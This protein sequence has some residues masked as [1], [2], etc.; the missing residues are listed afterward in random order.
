MNYLKY[1]LLPITIFLCFTFPYFGLSFLSISFM[2]FF[3]LHILIYFFLFEIFVIG[4]PMIYMGIMY[5]MVLFQRK[6]FGKSRFVPIL[7]SFFWSLGTLNFFWVIIE[8]GWI[9]ELF[10]IRFFWNYDWIKTLLGYPQYIGMMI[11]C[12]IYPL[13]M[14][15]DN[16]ENDIL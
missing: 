5:L 8:S 6:L 3:D 2:W 9:Y 4:L 15:Y 14:I 16:G 13:M 12:I 10:D 1:L 11:F 7:H